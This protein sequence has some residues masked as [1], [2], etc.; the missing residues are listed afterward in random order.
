MPGPLSD[1]HAVTEL[2]AQDL[3][4]ARRF[5]RDKLRDALSK[6]TPRCRYQRERAFE[7]RQTEVPR[8]DQALPEQHLTLLAQNTNLTEE[9]AR[10]TTEPPRC[11][12]Q[13]NRTE[14]ARS[15]ST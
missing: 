12:L 9:I 7:D 13:P 10:L 14:T 15:R 1:A 4:R 8:R 11:D 2:P 5:Y 6:R 3:E